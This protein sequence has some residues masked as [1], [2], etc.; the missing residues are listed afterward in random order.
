MDKWMIKGRWINEWMN[1]WIDRWING[2]INECIKMDEW[3][4][5]WM[6][7]W[8]DEWLNWWINACWMDEWMNGLFWYTNITCSV[9]FSWVIKLKSI[10]SLIKRSD[11][12]FSSDTNHFI[13]S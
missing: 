9:F 11:K 3:T 4:T 1:G 8:M 6:D 7:S 2:W 12:A 13:I 5:E 10:S